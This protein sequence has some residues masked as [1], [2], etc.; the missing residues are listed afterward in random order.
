MMR[1]KWTKRYAQRIPNSRP[2]GAANPKRKAI[3]KVSPPRRRTVK[4]PLKRSKAVASLKRLSPLRTASIWRGRENF[5]STAVAAAASGGETTAPR[6]MPAA[7]G[8]PRNAQLI[9]ATTAVVKRT[10]MTAYVTSGATK[11]RVAPGGKS[12]AASTTAGA[13]KSARQVEGSMENAG[14]LGI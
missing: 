14:A 7:R 8:K 1:L 9:Q 5:R 2:P 4:A 13:I 3:G 11:R 10:A 12:N 6:A